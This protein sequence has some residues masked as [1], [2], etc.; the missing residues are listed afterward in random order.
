MR[1]EEKKRTSQNTKFQQFFRKRWVFPAIYLM[2]AAVILTAVLWYQSISNNVAEDLQTPDQGENAMNDP[3]AVEVNA[4]KENVK[5]PALDPDA[6]SVV[7]KFYDPNASTEEQ[8]AALVSYNNSYRMNKGIDIANEDQK[9]FDV[10]ASLSG[11]V[12]KAT[13]DPILGYVV[14]IEHENDVVTVYQSLAEANVQA[15]DKVEQNELIGKAGKNLYNEEDGNHL[16]FEIRQNGTAINPLT[17]MDKPVTS[18]EEP[19][20]EEAT[21]EEATQEE[22]PSEDA[23]APKEDAEADDKSAEE[24]PESDKDAQKG[25]TEGSEQSNEPEASNNTLNS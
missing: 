6:V 14:E 23:E 2:S 24:S 1:E 15:G 20:Q 3:E 12:T 8:E 21:Q 18:I 25:E 22:A 13:K 4:L 11:T 10:V 5:M 7:K 19:V 9:Q 16:H 17:Y